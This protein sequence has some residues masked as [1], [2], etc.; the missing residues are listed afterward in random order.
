MKKITR[1][2]VQTMINER[3]GNKISSLYKEYIKPLQ[4]EIKG[5]K[6]KLG[7][8][9]TEPDQLERDK[10][11]PKATLIV[12]SPLC[13]CH[14]A[15]LEQRPYDGHL[16]Y[17][18]PS[19]PVHTKPEPD[20]NARVAKAMGRTIVWH[21]DAW[22]QKFLNEITCDGGLEHIPDYSHDTGL[23]IGALEEY[24][25]KNKLNAEIRINHF[26]QYYHVRLWRE[27]RPKPYLAP[28][29]IEEELVA[30]L[31]LPATICLAIVAHAE[32][33]RK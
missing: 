4:A 9:G 32:G 30:N 33:S 13:T 17:R 21:K 24:C 8:I 1:E 19:C 5:I 3:V 12:A 14:F 6:R 26:S 18:D 27:E 11:R 31:F 28:V 15:T 16:V 25:Q 20:L 2:E 23:A 29:A 7:M 22:Y 10:K